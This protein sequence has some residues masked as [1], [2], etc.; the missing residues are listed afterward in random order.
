VSIR[1]EDL[2]GRPSNALIR[3]TL[4]IL[5]RAEYPPLIGHWRAIAKHMQNP[6]SN[7]WIGVVGHL[8]ES[9]PNLRIVDLNFTRTQSLNGFASDLRIVVSAQSAK[10][11]ARSDRLQ[12]ALGARLRG[13]R[14]PEILKSS[15]DVANRVDNIAARGDHRRDQ[16]AAPTRLLPP[17][18]NIAAIIASTTTRPG[19]RSASPSG[20]RAAEPTDS[21][22][23]AA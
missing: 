22:R 2:P 6:T 7:V 8:K 9:L 11:A 19:T 15:S 13:S 21:P 1:R 23:N 4:K 17:L 10:G 5:K 3:V 18:I 12:D 20:P 16:A 14:R